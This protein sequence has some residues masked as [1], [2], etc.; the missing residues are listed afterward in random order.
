MSDQKV[1]REWTVA[2][3][4]N[5]N[6]LGPVIADAVI[7]YDLLGT[8]TNDKGRQYMT[9]GMV[10]F[11]PF[12][13]DYIAG[14]GKLYTATVGGQFNINVRNVQ[15]KTSAEAATI[16]T[17]KSAVSR[18]TPEQKAALLEELMAE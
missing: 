8:R 6:V 9:T 5:G 17:A 14:D 18:L 7:K 3:V 16:E 12:Q 11:S 13:Y 15:L 2:P 1:K 4:N 10:N